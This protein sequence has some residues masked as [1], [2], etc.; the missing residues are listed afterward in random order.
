[1]ISDDL[2]FELEMIKYERG[3]EEEHEQKWLMRTQYPRHEAIYLYCKNHA[4][5]A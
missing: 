1:M 5:T 2:Y 3:T 4:F